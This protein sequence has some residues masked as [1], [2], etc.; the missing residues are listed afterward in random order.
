MTTSTREQAATDRSEMDRLRG[1]LAAS[2]TR[3]D[4]LAALSDD[5]RR[6]VMEK[7]KPTL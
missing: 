6:Q 3:A 7:Q 2:R 5:L 4:Q 1:E